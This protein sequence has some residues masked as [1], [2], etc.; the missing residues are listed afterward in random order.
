[1]EKG[2]AE[3]SHGG[4]TEYSSDIIDFEVLPAYYIQTHRKCG[5]DLDQSHVTVI[6]L[7]TFPRQVRNGTFPMCN[8][9]NYYRDDSFGTN[10]TVLI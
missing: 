4:V 8:I 2:Q 3:L 7:S 10:K 9:P 5:L 6:N 1:M